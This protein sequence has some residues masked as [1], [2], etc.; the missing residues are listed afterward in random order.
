MD[1]RQQIKSVVLSNIALI[2]TQ[3]IIVTFFASAVAIILSWIPHGRVNLFF[4][5]IYNFQKKF[6]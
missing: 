4:L 1:T 2:Q 5:D 6:R 3:A